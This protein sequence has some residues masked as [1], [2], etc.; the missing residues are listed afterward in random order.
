MF[1]SMDLF[2]EMVVARTPARTTN[3]KHR[4]ATPRATNLSDN[5][6]V[7]KTRFALTTF[8]GPHT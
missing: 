3:V 8:L 2:I 7:V 6:R 4:D 1:D 5:E